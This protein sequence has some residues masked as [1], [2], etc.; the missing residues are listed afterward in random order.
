VR[1]V[2]YATTCA[3][4]DNARPGNGR[5]GVYRTT[6]DI[7]PDR[8]ADAIGVDAPLGY[9]KA[10]WQPYYE[11]TNSCKNYTEPVAVIELT[12]PTDPAFLTLTAYSGKGSV[13]LDE[14]GALV[15]DQLLT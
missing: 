1:L 2:A 15:R 7:P 14:L 5:H 10:F 13:G 3:A 6:A 9:T 8:S 11:C 4:G 12:N